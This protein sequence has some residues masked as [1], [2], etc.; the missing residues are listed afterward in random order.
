MKAD[1]IVALGDTERTALR[2]G[3]SPSHFAGAVA[4]EVVDDTSDQDEP[5]EGADATKE[6]PKK[7]RLMIYA[8]DATFR[9]SQSV[10]IGMVKTGLDALK[11]ISKRE[12]DDK[13]VLKAPIKVTDVTESAGLAAIQ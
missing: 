13:G 9:D 8:A 12:L 2:V 3:N 10:T 4:F 6:K 1:D 5:A 7:L 11:E